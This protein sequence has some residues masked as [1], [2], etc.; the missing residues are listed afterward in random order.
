MSGG[1]VSGG[2]VSGG[3]LSL[4]RA[5]LIASAVSVAATFTVA[6]LGPSVMEPALPGAAGQPPWAFAA[7]P[8]AGLAVGLTGL[9]LTAGA[10]GLGLNLRALHRGWTARPRPVLL[11]GIL[12]A[13]ALALVPPFGSS[14]HLSYAA[15]GRMV[16]TGHDPY[17]T[18][19]VMLA[20]LGDP[21]ARAVQDWRGSPSVYGSL[22]S[23]L[24]AL[25]SAAGGTS[26][27]LTVFVL[28]LLNV[29]AFAATGLLLHR[30]TRGSQVG[31]LRAALLWTCNPL[32]LQVLVA[33]AHVDSQ[34]IVFAVAAVAVFCLSLRGAAVRAGPE[35]AGPGRAGP[36]RAGPGRQFAVCA[37]AGALAG[38]GTAV[39]IT[40]VLVLAGLLA[41][42]VLAAGRFLV[43]RACGL[44]TG[45]VV[46]AALALV[47]WG[48]GALR[49]AWRA[50]SMVSI[51]SPWRTVRLLVRLGAGAGIAD[52][53]VKA[54][55]VLLAAV[56][57]VLLVNA[58]APR[59]P[60]PGGW[61]RPGGWHRPGGWR[62]GV[63]LAPTT[64]EHH[65]GR[66]H[67]DGSAGLALVCA[68]AFAFGWLMAWPYVLPW[69]DGL[70]WALLPLSA[71]PRPALPRPA[72]PRPARPACL[73]VALDWLMLARTT[74]LGF[75]YLPARGLT[76]PSGLAWLRPVFRNA[77]SPLALL[78]ILVILLLLLLRRP[79]RS[80]RLLG[81]VLRLLG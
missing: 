51:G 24:Q 48:P 55:A 19:P 31:Q 4:G 10:L 71:L 15:Y 37:G 11:A 57:V 43:A 61:Q 65:D 40:M 38:L 80:G 44:V 46:I 49:P 54:A 81:G 63:D 2:S 64:P 3:A 59:A 32:L 12:A 27:R 28:S 34:A 7:H 74:A 9:A 18:T 13:A 20:R 35:R 77:V 26:V 25:A 30:L 8:P 56:L 62:R 42:T 33:G 72:L 69:Y 14:D 76:M 17:T 52:D 67:A 73:V 68:F 39:K 66:I 50:G 5:G 1:S 47:P 21:V 53:V 79:R 29:A 78:T 23:G 22:A 41:A 6:V 58:L 45:F 60:D 75:A 16:V 70:G 36:G